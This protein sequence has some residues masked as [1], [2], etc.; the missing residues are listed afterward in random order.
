[1]TDNTAFWVGFM[2]WVT[3]VTIAL[4]WAANRRKP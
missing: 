1:M 3:F 2:F 4:H